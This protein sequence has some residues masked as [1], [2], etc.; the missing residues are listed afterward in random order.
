MRAILIIS[1]LSILSVITSISKT[2]PNY[3]PEITEDKLNS[4]RDLLRKEADD[5]QKWYLRL[6]VDPTEADLNH[7]RKISPQ[8]LRKCME[9]VI[10]PKGEE[11]ALAIHPQVVKETK[12]GI[13]LL[14][15][16]INYKLNYKQFSELLTR[17]KTEHFV[18]LDRAKSN[19]VA[20]DERI[21]YANDL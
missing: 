21:E 1:L 3:I 12:A 17:L 11:A 7:D 20:A 4:V 13:D 14:V 9:K 5:F 16:N 6:I 10:L 8:E 19:S 2:H 15:A 18:N